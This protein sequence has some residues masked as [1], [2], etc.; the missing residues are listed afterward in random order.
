MTNRQLIVSFIRKV[1]ERGL[2]KINPNSWY[3]AQFFN[4]QIAYIIGVFYF[5]FLYPYDCPSMSGEIL[6]FSLISLF[7]LM[8]ICP[9]CFQ[10][11]LS[12]WNEKINAVAAYLSF[13]GKFNIK[14]GKRLAH[15]S[16]KVC[17]PLILAI[18]RERAKAGS[19]SSFSR[20]EFLSTFFTRICL[21]INGATFP[22][23]DSISIFNR[24]RNLKILS[25]NGTDLGG[26]L[27]GKRLDATFITAKP[28]SAFNAGLVAVNR[29]ATEIAYNIATRFSAFMVAFVRAIDMLPLWL[30]FFNNRLAAIF[31]SVFKRHG[32]P[33]TI[34]SHNY[35]ALGVPC[36]VPPNGR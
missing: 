10:G 15:R 31:T 33:S 7:V 11:Y 3:V 24:N 17:F 25:T 26:R 8:P 2:K 27:Y 23:T 34:Y 32:A 4:Q 29:F 5:L 12:F 22:T 36:Q 1:K 28:L 35:I 9:I 14:R 13:L 30:L 21:E 20:L 18:T 16:F 19:P 6:C